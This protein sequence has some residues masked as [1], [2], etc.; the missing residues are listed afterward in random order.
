AARL[1]QI[2]RQWTQYDCVQAAHRLVEEAQS[3]TG[4]SLVRALG[5]EGVLRD[6]IGYAIANRLYLAHSSATLRATIPLDSFAHWFDGADEGL[7]PDLLLLEAHMDGTRFVVDATI[8]ECK[9]G[10]YS[11]DHVE[12]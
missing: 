5:D 6:V 8:V 11:A 1:A 3:V 12:E 7:I 2:Y 4:L 9:V 10:Q